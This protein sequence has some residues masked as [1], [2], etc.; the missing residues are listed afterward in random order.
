MKKPAEKHLAAIKS[1]HID[2]GNVIGMRKAFNHVARIGR[3]WSVSPSAPRVS[4]EEV[5][6]MQA[7][8]ENYRPKVTGELHETGK[9]LLQSRRYAKRWNEVQTHAISQIDH[10]RLIGFEEN[11][12][13]KG[14]FVPVY[15]V[16]A[17]DSMGLMRNAFTFWNIPWQSGGNGPEILRG[18]AWG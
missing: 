8:L 14:S 5:D 18:S 2:K 6:A 7:A 17:R 12:G 1:G 9:A 16:W 13:Q 11:P 4:F 15:E 3:G 10:F